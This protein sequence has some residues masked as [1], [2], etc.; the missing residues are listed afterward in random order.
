MDKMRLKSEE[1]EI[2]QSKWEIAQNKQ[3][4]G[5]WVGFYK[6]QVRNAPNKEIELK[7]DKKYGRISEKG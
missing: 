1:R 4:Q 5:K 3:V 6:N 7:D 2:I